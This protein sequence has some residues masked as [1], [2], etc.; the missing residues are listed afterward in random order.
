LA[1]ERNLE[2]IEQGQQAVMVAG[3]IRTYVD[4]RMREHVVAL[5]GLYRNGAVGAISH[6]ML[7]GKVAE[8]TALSDLL[9]DLESVARRGETA[10]RREFGDGQKS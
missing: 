1:N 10:A 8:I 4:D 7:I 2:A 6:D 3:S 9:S 5:M